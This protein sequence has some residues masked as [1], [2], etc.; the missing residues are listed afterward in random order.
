MSRTIDYDYLVDSAMRIVILNALRE[1]EEYNGLPGE[2]YFYVTFATKYPGV[3]VSQTLR[4]KYSEEMTIALQHQL[5]LLNVYYDRFEVNL[6]FG[7]VEERLIV[8]FGAITRFVDPHVNFS[9]QMDIDTKAA[10]DKTKF[11]NMARDIDMMK[12]KEE[13]TDNKIIYFSDIQSKFKK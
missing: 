10:I 11:A 13:E 9:V 12:S 6:S 3:Q 2:H 1:V 4:D 7:G 8:P 5:R